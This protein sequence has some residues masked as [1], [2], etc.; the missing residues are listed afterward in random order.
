MP[1]TTTDEL[2]E[3][4]RPAYGRS[5]PTYESK[6]PLATSAALPAGHGQGQ[7]GEPTRPAVSMLDDDDEMLAGQASGGRGK[8]IANRPSDRLK[9]ILQEVK[10]RINGVP[11]V[12]DGER[13][14]H[15]NNP[16]MNDPF[17]FCNNY[18]STSKYN[19]VSF[20]PKFFAGTSFSSLAAATLTRAEQFSKYANVFF[21]FTACIQ[22]IPN[23]SPTNKYTTIAPLSLVLLVA[24]FKEV[25]EDLVRSCACGAGLTRRSETTPVRLGSERADGQGARRFRL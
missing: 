6:A 12:L 10:D 22:Q 25:Q 18:V 7:I 16:P 9:E 2:D 15:I 1:T 21:L 13:T 8:A 11:K 24:A 4:D 20:V 17:K 19:L 23:V 5:A 3:Y 14:I